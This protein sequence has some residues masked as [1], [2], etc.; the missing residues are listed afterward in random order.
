M[1]IAYNHLRR[2]VVRSAAHGESLAR[3]I[4]NLQTRYQLGGCQ[5]S[6]YLGTPKVNELQITQLI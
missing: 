5:L 3:I 4:Q 1:S 6:L 2:S